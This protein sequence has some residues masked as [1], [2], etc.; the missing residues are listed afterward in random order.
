[1]PLRSTDTTV[2]TLDGLR[3]SG[4]LVT[5]ENSSQQAIILV[6]GGGVTREEGGFFTRLVTGLGEAG[7][8]SLRFDLCGYGQSEGQQQ[9]L[10][11]SA[12]LNDIRVAIAHVRTESGTYS[13]SLLGASFGGGICGYYAAKRPNEITRLVLLNPQFDYK[14]RTIDNRPYWAND[15]ISDEAA[16]QLTE[17]GHID[18]TP[19]LKHGRAILNEVFWL[20]PDEVLGEITAPTLVVARHQGHLRTDRVITG[21]NGSVPDPAQARGDR[22]R[23]ARL[24]GPRRSAVPQPAKPGVAS[25]RHPDGD[26]LAHH[27]VVAA[28]W[29]AA[30]ASRSSY[31]AGRPFHGV[32]VCAT[33]A[34]TRSVRRE[35]V[36]I[37]TSTDVSPLVLPRQAHR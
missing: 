15:Y 17:Q 27:R 28:A 25:V 6:H 11:L 18:F 14:K 8:T 24:R 16:Q 9:D 19:T 37:A 32:S 34:S 1:M 26:G 36:A 30:I 7:V 4:T 31:T 21:G 13:V 35:L 3:L 29:V 5:P 10:T 12:I 22:G 2:R 23:P 20:K 33:S